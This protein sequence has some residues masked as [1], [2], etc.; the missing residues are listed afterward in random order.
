ME[1]YLIRMPIIRSNFL[2][3]KAAKFKGEIEFI[4]NKYGVIYNWKIKFTNLQIDQYTTE[5]WFKSKNK[6]FKRREE[7]FNKLKIKQIVRPKKGIRN[8][9][10]ILNE[11]QMRIVEEY[12]NDRNQYNSTLKNILPVLK[13]NNPGGEAK[14]P[15][16]AEMVINNLFNNGKNFVILFDDLTAKYKIDFDVLVISSEEKSFED[17]LK[18]NKNLESAFVFMQKNKNQDSWIHYL[19]N[20]K[21]YFNK[22]NSD[23]RKAHSI[24][25]KSRNKF[26]KNINNISKFPF[27]YKSSDQFQKCHIYEFHDLR[28]KIIE[29]LRSNKSTK[30]YELMIEDEDNFIPLPESIHRKF[31]ANYFTYNQDGIIQP[32]CFKGEKF[33]NNYVEEKFK[34]IPKDFLN[35]KR[36][37]YIEM[38]NLNIAN[39]F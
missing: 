12:F 16:S 20:I 28:D 23:L 35:Q 26:S 18:L 34:K 4:S 3:T 25:N 5:S 39:L 36:K 22:Y 21:R 15:N 10:I 2:T 13:G 27:G 30:K 37:K 1:S 9:I 29:A 19:S 33:I 31:D 14:K 24:A 7:L 32:I 8:K 38:R 11:M 6:N 17:Y